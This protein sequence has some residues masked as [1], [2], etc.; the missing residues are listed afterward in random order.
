MEIFTE[1]VR[2]EHILTR[3]DAR[4][5][6]VLALALLA[7]VLSYRSFLFPAAIAVLCLSLILTMKVPVRIIILRFS[8]PL[9][10]ALVLLILKFFFSGNEPLFSASVLGFNIVGHRDGLM[11]GLMIAG[12]IMAAVSIVALVGFATPFTEFMAG[13][14]WLRMPKG[15]IEILMFAYRYIFVLADDA[16]VI[17][18]AQKNRLGYSS[19]RRG[20]SSFGVLAGS[21]T[22]KA[23]DHSQNTTVAMM[24]RGYD[25][26]MPLLKQK[27]FRLSEVAASVLLLTVMG[28]LWKM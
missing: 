10:I 3:V 17:Y 5:K 7:M 25:G 9:V 16:A 8:E 12:R 15:F 14:S 26:N 21:L 11:E 27:S 23:F 20:L 4:V 13:L 6:L 19:I 1:Q 2:H 28:F 18:S 22:L 24:Q